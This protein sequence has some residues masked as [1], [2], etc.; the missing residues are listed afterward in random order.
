[1]VRKFLYII[2]GLI[3]LALAAMVVLRLFADD[4]S[5]IAFEPEA[6][7]TPLPPAQ[8]NAYRAMDMWIA[9]PGI[10]ADDPSRWTPAGLE[11]DADALAVPVFFIHPTSYLEKK[12]WNAPLDDKASRDRAAVFVRGMASPFNKSFNIWAPR[13]RQ[14]A[15]GAFLSHKPEAKQALD[16]AYGDVA[17]AFDQFLASIDPEQPFVIAGHSQGAL[18]AMRLLQGKVA[19]TPLARRVAAAYIIG[20]T[21]SPEHDLPA[22]GLP[23]CTAPEQTG[24]VVS[25]SSFAEPAEPPAFDPE[26][27]AAIALDGQSR[28]GK[29]PLCTNPLTGMTGGSAPASANAGTLVPGKDLADG[30]LKA[31]LVPA[32]CGENGLLLIGPPPE[33]GQY[34]LPGNNYHVYDI[35]LFWRNLRMDFDRRVKAW[36]ASA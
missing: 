17:L 1:M 14:A 15:F 29:P 23:A 7:F 36:K 25:W 32:R 4:L 21:V 19:G 30:T 9:R 27:P 12:L 5:R 34:V 20:W 6:K 35:L 33:M 8:P 2:A 24:C 3:V 31:G 11:E 18:M 13:Y 26:I 28:A 10:G 22:M 16:I